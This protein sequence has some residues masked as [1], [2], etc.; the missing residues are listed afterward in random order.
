MSF[1]F[2]SDAT[3]LSV[4][5]SGPLALAAFGYW[6]QCGSWTSANGKTGIVPRAIAIEF[7]GEDAAELISLLTAE[8]IWEEIEGGFRMLRGP[9]SDWP[10]PI[11]RY[12]EKPDDGRLISVDGDSLR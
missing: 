3:D 6:V 10:L 8:G 1:D 11:W 9:S 5:R 7:A 2:H 12:G 4:F